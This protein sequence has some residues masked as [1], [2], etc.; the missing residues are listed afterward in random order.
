MVID[1]VRGSQ[2]RGPAPPPFFCMK[3]ATFGARNYPCV[4]ESWVI[5]GTKYSGQMEAESTATGRAQSSSRS[6]FRIFRPNLGVDWLHLL[7]FRA[8]L[9]SAEPKVRRRRGVSSVLS[10]NIYCGRE[11]RAYDVSRYP[12]DGSN[13][14]VGPNLGVAVHFPPHRPSLLLFGTG[15]SKASRRQTLLRRSSKSSGRITHHGQGAPA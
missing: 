5:S 6:A 10:C 2:R 1:A 9:P 4:F 11:Q 3:W 7:R 13:V 15:C 12:H 14:A 8:C